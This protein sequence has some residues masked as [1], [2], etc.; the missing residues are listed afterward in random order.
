MVMS[1]RFGYTRGLPS[2]YEDTDTPALKAEREM[3]AE[4]AESRSPQE[5]IEILRRYNRLSDL[6]E[7]PVTRQMRREKAE[8]DA[9]EY[10]QHLRALQRKQEE[11]RRYPRELPPVKSE[12]RE[13]DKRD[14]EAAVAKGVSSVQLAPASEEDWWP[15]DPDKPIG[16]GDRSYQRRFQHESTGDAHEDTLSGLTAERGE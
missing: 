7:N 12:A 13:R 3:L 15:Y 2:M 14:A 4:I 9:E 6:A 5:Y 8:L 11:V 16:D 1:G 10:R